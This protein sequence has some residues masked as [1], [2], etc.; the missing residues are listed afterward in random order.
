MHINL[1]GNHFIF[2]P[3]KGNLRVYMLGEVNTS[4]GGREPGGGVLSWGALGAAAV[5]FGFFGDV[6]PQLLRCFQQFV[7]LFGLLIFC[8]DGVLDPPLQV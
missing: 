2:Q 5:S 7:H 4:I 1:P 6:I 8:V 3:Y